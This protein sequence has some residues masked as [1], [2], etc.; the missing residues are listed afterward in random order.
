LI[1]SPPCN[2]AAAGLIPENSPK[3]SAAC[4][5]VNCGNKSKTCV[6]VVIGVSLIVPNIGRPETLVP[7]IPNC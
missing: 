6:K 5:A 3:K 2:R 1:T 7:P 4:E